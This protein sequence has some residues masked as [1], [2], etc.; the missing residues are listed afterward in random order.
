MNRLAERLPQIIRE[1]AR[2]P[3]GILA[4]VVLAVSFLGFAFFYRSS[5]PVKIVIFVLILASAGLFVWKIIHLLLLEKGDPGRVTR[6]IPTPTDSSNPLPSFLITLA[7]EDSKHFDVEAIV[8]EED[9]QL[10]MSA[11]TEIHDVR[12][13]FEALVK[14]AKKTGRLQPG[15]VIVKRGTPVKLLAIIHDLDEE[16]TWREEW[17]VG[18]LQ[19]VLKQTERRRI[20]S[21]AMPLLGCRHGRLEPRRFAEF[22]KSA[23]SKTRST[24]LK[25]LWLVIPKGTQR[26]SLEALDDLTSNEQR[27]GLR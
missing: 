6:D 7:G 8:L 27:S 18:A 1:A 13:S 17:I 10:V 22:L 21:L 5:E 15:S 3:L 25:R 9:T 2:S 12:E 11:G 16:P 24:K 23:I 26:E 19:E 14:R 20:T 4:L